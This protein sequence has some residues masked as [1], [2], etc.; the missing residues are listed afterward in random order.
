[1]EKITVLVDKTETNYCAAIEGLNGFVC[2]ADTLNEIETE[3]KEGLEFHLEGM[4]EDNDP[5]PYEFIGKYELIFQYVWE[6][7]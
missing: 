7:Q 4:K 6:K 3:A 5:I 2:T 1:M